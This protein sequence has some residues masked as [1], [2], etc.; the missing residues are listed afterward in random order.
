MCFDFSARDQSIKKQQQQFFGLQKMNPPIMD[1]SRT[2][3]VKVI[4]DVTISTVSLKIT[5]PFTVNGF[6][7]QIT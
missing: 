5:L 1:G 3:F 2:S 7:L 6:I 4:A